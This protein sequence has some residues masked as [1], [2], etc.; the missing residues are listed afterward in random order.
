MNLKYQYRY[1]TSLLKRYGFRGLVFKTLERSRSPMLAYTKCYRRYMP[2]EE[3]LVRQKNTVFP[4]APLVSIVVPA[5]ETPEGYLRDLI[6]SVLGQSYPNL[7]LCI[8]DG[9]TQDGVERIA[10]EY[11]AKDSRLRYQRLLKNGGISENTNCGFAMAKGEYIALMDHDDLLTKNALYE[12]V[13]CLNREYSEEERILAM[14]YSDEDKIN[15]DGTVHSRPHFKPDYNREFLRRNNYFCHFLMVSARL[16]EKAGGLNREYDGAQDYDFVLRCVDAGAV[17][18]H[19]PRILYH[20]RIHEGSTA[21]NSENKAYA[22]DNGCRAIEAHLK[23]NKEPGRA[24]VTENLGVYRVVYALKGEY[25]LTVIAESKEQLAQIRSYYQKQTFADK[26]Y[27]LKIHYLFANSFHNGIE[28]ECIGDYILYIRNDI[29]VEPKDLIEHFLG[30]CQQKKAGIVGARLVTSKKR[31]ASCGIIY[32]ENGSLIFSNEG[33]YSAYKGYF[34]HAVIPQNVSAVPLGCVMIKKEA[35]VQAEGFEEA[36]TGI[37]RDAD[38]CF[39]LAELGYDAVVTPEVTA[40]QYETKASKEKEGPA[41]ERQRKLF[42]ARWEQKL[43]LPDP[44]YN[45]NLSTKAGHTYTMKSGA[46]C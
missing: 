16:I 18:R 42:I 13:S 25:A 22:F 24:E 29:R 27:C 15:G 40:L 2:A 35:F 43:L 37:Y 28:K 44:C 34:L 7:E 31:V 12:M 30:I 3:E 17:V 19:V 20:W 45:P 14:I 33:I 1:I 41:G 9:S 6:E 5:Y 46:D 32:D 26:E 39:R 11:A 36:M 4:Y 38:F 8:A 21:G 23:R 10:T